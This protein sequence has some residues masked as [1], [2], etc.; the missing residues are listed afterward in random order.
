MPHSW[1]RVCCFRGFPEG[2]LKL[3]NLPS[4]VGEQGYSLLVGKI[5][6]QEEDT[7]T[8]CQSYT[9]TDT[10]GGLYIYSP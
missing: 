2:K 9:W 8:I 10:P 4:T 5:T 3:K 6:P 1:I 7:M